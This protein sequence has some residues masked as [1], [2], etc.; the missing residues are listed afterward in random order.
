[1]FGSHCN[2]TPYLLTVHLFNL[3]APPVVL[4]LAMAILAP[5][6]PGWAGAR[7]WVI[8]WQRRFFWG[9][10]V[11][12]VVLGISLLFGSPGKIQAYA[13]MLVACALANLLMLRGWHR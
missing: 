7:P 13:A 5:G 8:G 10:V 2:M 3:L 9:L 1:M 6:L 11:N 12:L 4:A